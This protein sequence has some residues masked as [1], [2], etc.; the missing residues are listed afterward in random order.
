MTP[1]EFEPKK[2]SETEPEQPAT[3]PGTERP[4][5]EY[6]PEIPPSRSPHVDI[7]QPD[8]PMGPITTPEP[9]I[10]LRG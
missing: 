6:A 4:G 9:S 1:I 2:S 10:P 5:H 7:P 8:S 3:E